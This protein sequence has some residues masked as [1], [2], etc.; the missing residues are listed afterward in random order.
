[1]S[2]GRYLVNDDLKNVDETYYSLNKVLSWHPFAR[3]E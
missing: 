3:A 2:S 1:V